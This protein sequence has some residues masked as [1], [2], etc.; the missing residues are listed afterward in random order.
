MINKVSD[1]RQR[2]IIGMNDRNM[3]PID[4]VK[5]TGIS[6]ST[7]SQYMSGYAEPKSDRLLLIANALYLNPTWLMGL[8]VPKEL[9]ADTRQFGQEDRDLVKAYT[10]ASPEAREIVQSILHLKK[11]DTSLESLKV[12]NVE[13]EQDSDLSKVANDK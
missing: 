6:D 2:L 12:A 9:E 5:K 10:M 13:N 7:I 1:F 3:R 11:Q 8:D 4:L